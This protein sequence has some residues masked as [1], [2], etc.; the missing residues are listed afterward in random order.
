MLLGAFTLRNDGYKYGSTI[1]EMHMST[2]AFSLVVLDGVRIWFLP[3]T[4]KNLPQDW[5]TRNAFLK[6]FINVH[7]L[8]F[9]SEFAQVLHVVT[10]SDR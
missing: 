4:E 2:H 7:R 1:L 8:S 3:A 6:L 9:F 10:L 5:C